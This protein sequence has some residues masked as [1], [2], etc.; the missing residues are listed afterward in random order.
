M[1][2]YIGG[3]LEDSFLVGY[4]LTF[5][6]FWI[7]IDTTAPVVL[8]LNFR[9]NRPMTSKIIKAII[10]DDVSGIKYY[11]GFID[12]EWV[13]FQFDLKKNLIYYEFDKDFKYGKH[14]IRFELEDRK[15]N[16]SIKNYEVIF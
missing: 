10:K 11:K 2:G 4:G 16:K 9:S 12:N 14:I 15:G 8:P 7:G 3:I 13:L 6:S 5:G 1:Q